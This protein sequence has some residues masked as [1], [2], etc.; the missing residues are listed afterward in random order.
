VANGLERGWRRGE[1][2]LLVLL[3]LLPYAS[4]IAMV[5]DVQIAPFVLSALLWHV[6]QRSVSDRIDAPADRTPVRL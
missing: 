4:V 3:F 6:W 1:R 2:A 5:V